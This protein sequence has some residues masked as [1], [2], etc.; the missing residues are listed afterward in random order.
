MNGDQ[1]TRAGEIHVEERGNMENEGADE[2]HMRI[3]SASKCD[4]N[5][6]S[7]AACASVHHTE[8]IYDPASDHRR[9]GVYKRDIETLKT[10]NSTLQTLI[11]A[12]LE[13]PDDQVMT[14]VYAIRNSDNLE[15][16]AE[17]VLEGGRYGLGP[18]GNANNEGGLRDMSSSGEQLAAAWGT[19]NADGKTSNADGMVLD[20][21]M[22]D[23]L[24]NSGGL[25]PTFESELSHRMSQLR[26][27]SESGQV[28]FIGGTSNLIMLPSHSHNN[29]AS[30]E[31]MSL[32]HSP[33]AIHLQMDELVG[34]GPE[35]ALAD[36]YVLSRERNPVLS[37][38]RVL[39]E[40]REEGVAIVHLVEM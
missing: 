11:R 5:F 18:G 31:I 21:D 35:M 3:L 33:S 34:S 1:T 15:E 14:L 28:R 40:S 16:V 22:N 6:P 9:K 23:A 12:I 4:G 32:Q 36:P 25:E 37:W 7:C 19:I 26:V 8:C 38:T 27:D 17:A 10:H 24:G 2:R 39:G 30:H 13:Y 29:Q 20:D